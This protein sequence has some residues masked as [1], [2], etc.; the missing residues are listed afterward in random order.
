MVRSGWLW[1]KTWSGWRN[2]LAGW[3][4]GESSE[5]SLS[6][7]FAF[8]IV[9]NTHKYSVIIL[10]AF[11]VSIFNPNWVCG[12]KENNERK[13]F[14]ER[15]VIASAAKLKRKYSSPQGKM[16]ASEKNVFMRVEREVKRRRVIL[17]SSGFLIEFNFSY[18]I[19]FGKGTLIRGTR[20]CG[21]M[22]GIKMFS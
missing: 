15:S 21:R 2:S 14:T 11:Q 5:T 22:W 20:P 19:Y 9:K 1:V 3:H 17:A 18:L 12:Q 6:F 10:K 4:L 16:L 13:I 7:L 8:P